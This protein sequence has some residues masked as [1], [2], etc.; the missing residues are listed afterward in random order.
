[1]TKRARKESVT[2]ERKRRRGENT[3][4]ERSFPRVCQREYET[5][6]ERK[7]E[8]EMLKCTI[9]RGVRR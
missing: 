7:M 6:T 8:R 4:F 3:Y 5:E 9:S 1:M 2:R